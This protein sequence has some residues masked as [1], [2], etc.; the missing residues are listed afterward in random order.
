[1]KWNWEVLAFQTYLIYQSCHLPSWKVD[2][3]DG[4]FQRV[5]LLP[6]LSDASLELNGRKVDG[7]ITGLAAELLAVHHYQTA[8]DYRLFSRPMQNKML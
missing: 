8:V 5:G 1:M 3:S 4:A 7:M 6:D 2:S